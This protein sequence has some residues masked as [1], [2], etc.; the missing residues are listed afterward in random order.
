LEKVEFENGDETLRDDV[1][2][3][4]LVYGLL[5]IQKIPGSMEI[6]TKNHLSLV[7][8]VYGKSPDMSHRI[9]SFQ[10]GTMDPTIDLHSSSFAPLD[11]YVSEELGELKKQGEGISYE[12]Y[13]KVV[14]TV[15]MLDK[16]VWQFTASTSHST[17][18][19][20]TPAVHFRYDFSPL[21][22]MYSE[23]SVS[24]SRFVGRILAIVG[25]YLSIAVFCVVM[26]NSSLS[27]L[28]KLILNDNRK[29][30]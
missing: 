7:K 3:G 28:S 8:D 23:K 18:K 30:G 13:L 9:E 5:L 15:Y 25:A 10:F 16:R 24:F 2:E 4:C 6:S 11:D 20:D 27:S 14:P 19:Y 26:C 17:G 21:S 29:H 1:S 22:I 12:Y